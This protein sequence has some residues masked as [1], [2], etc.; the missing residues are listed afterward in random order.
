MGM[1]LIRSH[2]YANLL[3]ESAMKGTLFQKCA[4]LLSALFLMVSCNKDDDPTPAPTPAPTEFKAMAGDGEVLLSWKA[5]NSEDVQSYSITWTPGDG[6]ASV[7]SDVTTYTATGLTN[8]TAYSFQI[9][10]VYSQGESEV[11]TI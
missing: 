8:G 11:A 9:K 10:A 3:I 6:S 5:A 2:E 1:G 7:A 4:L